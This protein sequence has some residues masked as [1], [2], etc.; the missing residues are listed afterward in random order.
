MRHASLPALAGLVLLCLAACGPETATTPQ[1]TLI[2]ASDS[3]MAPFAEATEAAWLGGERWAVL[4]PGGPEADLIDFSSSSRTTLGTKANLESP[5]SLFRAADTLYVGEPLKRRLTFWSLDG[6]FIRFEPASD[7]VRGALPRA[8]DAAGQFYI[9]LRPA[10]GADGSGNR[11]S[12]VVVRLSGSNV[13]TIAKLAPLDLAKVASPTGERFERRVFSGVD[14]WGAYSDGT[15]WLARVYHNRVDFRLPD[16][17]YIKGEPL[18]DRVLEVT[19][20]DRELFVRKF[21]EELRGTAEQ[22]PFAPIK[23]AFTNAFADAEG[24]IWLEGSRSVSDSVQRYNVV[25][26][27]GR[28]QFVAL[29]PGTGRAIA[30]SASEI[31][32]ADL[33]REGIR[34]RL[35]PIPTLPTASTDSAK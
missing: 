29:L 32:V 11:D 23:A 35:A 20:A 18:P 16:G 17:Q 22:L 33:L 9:E 3:V 19:R 2:P 15:V 28:L 10:A 4:L 12:A 24:R 8:R 6:T 21:P 26:R 25:G 27:D 31:L 30:A 14:R 5:F 13:D 34:L 7:L 1:V